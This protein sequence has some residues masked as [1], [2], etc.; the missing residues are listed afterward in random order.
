MRLCC[1][2]VSVCF[3]FCP[4]LDD[5]DLLVIQYTSRNST[6]WRTKRVVVLFLLTLTLVMGLAC[7]SRVSLRAQP[8]SSIYDRKSCEPLA[9]L[10]YRSVH[11]TMI[12]C[13]A[14]CPYSNAHILVLC[15]IPPPPPPFPPRPSA[16]TALFPVAC[17]GVPNCRTS[18]GNLGFCGAGLVPGA[19]TR[20]PPGTYSVCSA[21]VILS[22]PSYDTFL[23]SW[24]Y[25]ELN[26]LYDMLHVRS[27]G[28]ML[29]RLT[30]AAAVRVVDFL[31]FCIS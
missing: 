11:H 12:G 3:V 1:C 6:R 16:V 31:F 8:Y 27:D 18:D 22:V 5:R 17:V 13:M 23:G 28:W 9:R 14:Y 21:A 20:A 26:P 2:W 15:C 25:D 19:A 10:L 30:I 7:L 24:R 29:L 4:G